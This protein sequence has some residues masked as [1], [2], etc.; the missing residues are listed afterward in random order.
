MK[1]TDKTF[2]GGLCQKRVPL[3][4]EKFDAV[5]SAAQAK[6][7]GVVLA[8]AIGPVVDDATNDG[9]VDSIFH[10]KVSNDPSPGVLD[11]LAL[12]VIKIG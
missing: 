7:K 9:Y 2:Y 4:G 1:S 5:S 10:L 11:C 3:H 12:E 6:A 8:P